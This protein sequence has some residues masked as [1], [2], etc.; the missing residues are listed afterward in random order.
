MANSAQAR[1][2]ARQ[3]VKQRAHNTSL[4]SSLRTAVK[5]VQKAILA[6]DKAAAQSIYQD[7]V[8]VIDRIADKKII[9]KNKAARHKSR[10]SAQIK[11]LAAA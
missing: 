8:S 10:L 4:R 7:S 6:G 5:R 1:K 3:A 9:H 2:R 11:G